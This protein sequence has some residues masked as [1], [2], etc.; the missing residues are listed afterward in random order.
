[1]IITDMDKCRGIN[2]KCENCSLKKKSRCMEVCPTNAI[3]L[4][5]NKAFSCITC[6]MCSKHCPN[7]AIKKNKFGGYYVSRVRCNGCGT[8]EKVCPIKI[9]TMK[10]WTV[11]EKSGREKY[12]VYPDGICAMCGLCVIECENNARLYFD[13]N[14]LKNSKNKLMAERYLNVF[15]IKP[16]TKEEIEKN[17]KIEGKVQLKD[18][19]IEK[20]TINRLKLSSIKINSEK[21]V[22]CGKCIYICPKNT[23]LE[24]NPVDGCTKCNICRDVCPKDAIENGVVNE[25]K[26]VLCNA[27]IINCPKDVLKISDY[28]VIK[29]K[30]DKPTI[31]F[32]HCVN[33]GL[34][35]D[36]CPKNALKL[37][38]NKIY[39]NPENCILCNKCVELCPNEVRVN[40]GNYISGACVLCEICI[41]SCSEKAIEINERDKFTVIDSEECIACGTCGNVCP[42]NAIVV[43]INKFKSE[44]DKTIHREI[45]FNNDCVMCESC[46]I[47]CP[48]DIIPNTTNYKKYIDKEKSFIRTDLD[49]CI[50]CGLCNRICPAEA[51]DTGKI[52]LN[53]C[54]YCSACVNI[55]PTN[56]ISIYR[57]WNTEKEE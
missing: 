18:T 49:Y 52:N 27:C 21:C 47:H 34:C 55:C 54:E 50:F 37:V 57:L 2:T 42:N 39:Y 29:S 56:A 23:I 41:N 48:R 8:C 40:K 5:D 44:T 35:A 10:K 24:K 46:A 43:K 1:M 11:K 30:E 38:D 22:K 33:C 19:I 32:N 16:P 12:A 14:D 25:E 45:I 3:K 20:G 26:C 9:I 6:G 15:G 7:N 13:I 53:K 17:E 4:I 51:I 36:N 28:K 31:P